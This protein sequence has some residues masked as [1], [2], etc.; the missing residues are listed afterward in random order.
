MLNE[1][2]SIGGVNFELKILRQFFLRLQI[3][4]SERAKEW[5]DFAQL[6]FQLFGFEQQ[7]S[8]TKMNFKN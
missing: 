4:Q 5:L 1:R 8:G 6:K 3:V 7:F 2:S